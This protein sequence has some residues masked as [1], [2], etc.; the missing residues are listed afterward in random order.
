ML[1]DLFTRSCLASA[2]LSLALTVSAAA[3]NNRSFVAT[4]G[5]D[6]NA[7][8]ATAFCRTFTRALAVTNSGGEIVVVDSG[9]YGAATISQAVTISAVGIVASITQATAGQ[10]GFTINTS[11]NVTLIGLSLH[12]QGTGQ[13]G[14]LVQNVG[15]LFLY[16]ITSENFT[17]NGLEV[18][19][20]N[21]AVED[22]SFRLN[23]FNG[24]AIDSGQNAYVHNTTL[25]NNGT[26]L[27]VGNGSAAV[28]D[29]SAKYN[30]GNGFQAG[31]SFASMSGGGLGLVRVES[32][33][34]GVGLQ[35]NTAT[36][37][38]GLISCLISANRVNSFQIVSGGSILGSNPGTNIIVGA[39]VGTLGTPTPLQ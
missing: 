11:G 8:S 26:G 33:Y 2:I 32:V 10:N 23:G 5:N 22:S 27:V 25:N 4:T 34:N 36:S 12:G 20:G 19:A 9:G 3:Q 13:Q 7:C 16:N 30:S 37:R 31:Y 15:T 18:L 14:I 29:S 38:M 39:S 21:V 6:T 28:V 24:I 35:T 1:D 17:E